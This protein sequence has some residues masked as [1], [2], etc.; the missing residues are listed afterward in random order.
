MNKKQY[1]LVAFL[2]LLLTTAI[3]AATSLAFGGQRGNFE[4][5]QKVQQAIVA[6][7]YTAWQQAMITQVATIRQEASDL[8]LKINQDTFNKL[9]QAQQLMKDG[10][11]DEAKVIFDELG[12]FGP[13][14]HMGGRGM[15]R[16]GSLPTATAPAVK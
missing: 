13:M 10:K 11:R 8:E 3:V 16:S 14:G 12:M 1:L 15:G 4:E 9:I 2:G 6:N 5:Q 7:D